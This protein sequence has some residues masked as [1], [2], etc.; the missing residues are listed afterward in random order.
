M[1]KHKNN[2]QQQID[3]TKTWVFLFVCLIEGWFNKIKKKIYT[4]KINN[5]KYNIR[6]QCLIDS[7][8]Y[9]K[10]LLAFCVL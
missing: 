2:Y 1:R 7:E 10:L 8:T 5:N 3:F 9:K 6:K 4:Y